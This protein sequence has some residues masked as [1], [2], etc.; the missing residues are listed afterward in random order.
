VDEWRG[1]MS[2]EQENPVDQAALDQECLE[3]IKAT[4]QRVRFCKPDDRST[5]A[6]QYAVVA[7]ELEKVYAYFNTYVVMGDNT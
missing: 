6:R 7:T 3:R 5:K 2:E 1:K 4:L